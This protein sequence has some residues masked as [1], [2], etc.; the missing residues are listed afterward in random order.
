MSIVFRKAIKVDIDLKPKGGEA[1]ELSIEKAYG[2]NTG[3]G[4]C[5]G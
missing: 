2:T 1:R 3:V 4:M 5:T